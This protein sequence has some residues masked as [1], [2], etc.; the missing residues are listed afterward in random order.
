MALLVTGC[1][2]LIG[3]QVTAQLLEQGETVVGV[4]NL[5]SYYLPQLKRHRLEPMLARSGFRFVEMDV[6]DAAALD[7]LVATQP[8]AAVLHL[9]AM[10]GVRYSIRSP[11]DYVLTNVLGTMNVLESM[12]RYGIGRMVLAS[13]SSL[14]A[15]LQMPFVENLPVNQPLS[16]YA[17][18]KKGAEALAWTWHHLYGIHVAVVRYFT[19]YGPAGRPDMS[20]FRFIHQIESGMPLE[21]FGDGSQARDFT[22]VRD[23]ARGTVAAL[24]SDGFEVYNLGGNDP[25]TVSTMIGMIEQITGKRAAIREL[26]FHHADMKATWANID[27]AGTRLGWRPEIRLEEGLR[28]CV[29]WY[30]EHRDLARSAVE[31]FAMTGPT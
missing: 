7:Q 31:A 19:V 15:G 17:A 10:A 23:I 25:L 1:A 9:A 16:P 20:Y 21:L 12:Q 6:T 4:D 3:A 26:P 5:N 28:E 11:R 2:G 30:R 27:K 24:G 22:H 14:Y 8:F 29:G 13:T 18:S